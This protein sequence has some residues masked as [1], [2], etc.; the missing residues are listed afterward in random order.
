MKKPM[1]YIEVEGGIVTDVSSDCPIDY[2][3]IDWDNIRAGDDL[4]FDEYPCS[5]YGSRRQ[6]LAELIVGSV[7]AAMESEIK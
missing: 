7:N 6:E 2:V 1:V 3:L 5:I 4:S